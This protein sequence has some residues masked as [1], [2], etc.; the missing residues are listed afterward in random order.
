MKTSPASSFQ[1]SR[2][3]LTIIQL[4]L[5]EKQRSWRSSIWQTCCTHLKKKVF[6]GFLLAKKSA[7]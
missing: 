4:A 2:P 6:H 3:V 7:T 5:P 1:A